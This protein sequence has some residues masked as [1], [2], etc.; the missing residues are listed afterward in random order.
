MSKTRVRVYIATSID[1]FIA[2]PGGDLSWLPGAEHAEDLDATAAVEPS[3]GLSYED[4][5]ADVGSILMGRGTYDAVR[6]FGVPWPYG[7]LPVIV[8]SRR[9]LDSGAPSTVQ[10]AAADIRD[11]VAMASKAAAGKDLYLDGGVLIRQALQAGLVDEITM[12]MAPVALGA[13]HSLFAGLQSRA[14]FEIAAHHPF[15]HGMLQL[16][17]VPRR[18]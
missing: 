12:T 10:R 7:A 4:F 8:A 18:R 9:S 5:I 16:R 2:G 13:G 6:G 1:G 17:L 15:A 14:R 11:L 3:Q